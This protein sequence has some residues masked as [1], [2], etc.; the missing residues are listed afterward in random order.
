MTQRDEVVGGKPIA[1]G[2]SFDDARAYLG[3]VA[4][5]TLYKLD[6]QGDIRSYKVG[7]RRFFTRESLDGY[8]DRLL[9]AAECSKEIG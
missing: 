8:I 3:G 2:L 7:T 1:R 9:E 5:M 6:A 4:R